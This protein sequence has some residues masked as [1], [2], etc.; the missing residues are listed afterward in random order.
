MI[1][2]IDALTLISPFALAKSWHMTQ[3]PLALRRWKRV[4]Y[5]RLVDLGV[6]EG[7]PLKLIGGEHR[8]V[9]PAGGPSTEMDRENPAARV[10][11]RTSPS[12]SPIW[13]S[14]RATRPT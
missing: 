10:A 13:S 12:P 8:R 5:D 4:E 14:L 11:R 1:A 6:F 2:R 7:E 3:A 9:C